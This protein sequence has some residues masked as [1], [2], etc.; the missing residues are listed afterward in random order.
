MTRG[1]N[2]RDGIDRQGNDEAVREA[3]SPATLG[4][5]G[6]GASRGPARIDPLT[7]EVSGA[8]SG[9]GGSSAGEDFDDDH[10]AGSNSVR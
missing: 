9:T 2:D 10:A 7:G 6:N 4:T 5:P 8:G 1:R 3:L